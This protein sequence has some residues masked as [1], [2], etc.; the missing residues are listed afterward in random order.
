MS[1]ATN[2]KYCVL[3]VDGGGVR[4]II[5]A[6]LLKEIELRTGKTIPE[7]FDLALGTS[8]GGLITIAS[9]CNFNSNDMIDLYQ[10]SSAKIF[11]YSVMRAIATVGGL[12][13]PKY[14]RDAL[15]TLLEE[16]FGDTLLS[17]ANFPICITS[18]NLDTA[19]PEIWSS[20]DV[21]KGFSPDVKL[22]DLAGAT[23]AAPTYFAP[24]E[25]YDSE[26]VLHHAIDG[27]M[28]LNNP[29]IYAINEVLKHNPGIAREEI[30]V[31]SIGTGN[32]ELKWDTEALKNAGILGWIKGGKII[33]VMMDGNTD[34]SD[35]TAAIIYPN[36]HRLQIN[37]PK[38][39]GEMDNTS[40]ENL[41]AL[42]EKA[43]EYI[44]QNSALFDE[45][46]HQLTCSLVSNEDLCSTELAA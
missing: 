20:E 37:L 43:E 38:E 7:L 44:A 28:F 27:G 13:G 8:T 14:D 15:D 35:L 39:L 9:A 12:E 16:Y 17:E 22:K 23:S 2:R 40:E 6:R 33:D 30:L 34:F 46:A 3:S 5:P 32:V 25:F 41:A 45:I 1:A 10:N 19:A 4:G 36:Y 24:K 21:I 11:P 31:V 29:Q 26:G 18:Y 42:L